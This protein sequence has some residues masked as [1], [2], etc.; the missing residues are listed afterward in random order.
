MES[1][2]SSSQY[3]KLFK[4]EWKKDI[5][6]ILFIIALLVAAYGYK[7]DIGQCKEVAMHPCQYCYFGKDAPEFIAENPTS[8]LQCN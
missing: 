1:T 4:F 3:S 8:S 7:R 6:W 2:E 5:W